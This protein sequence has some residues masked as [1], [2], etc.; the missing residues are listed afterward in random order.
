MDPVLDEQARISI[1]RRW[2]VLDDVR[3]YVGHVHKPPPY[4]PF[5]R[6]MDSDPRMDDR[7]C[8]LGNW[9]PP[10]KICSRR[11]PAGHG[12]VFA[13]TGAWSLDLSDALLTRHLSSIPGTSGDLRDNTASSFISF[14][15]PRTAS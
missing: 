2:C 4:A 12:G 11:N 8:R 7:Y 9:L 5:R 15:R 13:V 1:R 6:A 10:E 14:C 3:G